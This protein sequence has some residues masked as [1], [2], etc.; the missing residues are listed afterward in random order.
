MIS[1]FPIHD[2]TNGT[3]QGKPLKLDQS[4]FSRTAM[5][6]MALGMLLVIVAWA[7]YI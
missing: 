5:C 6:I 1:S 7:G 3:F 4:G 2:E